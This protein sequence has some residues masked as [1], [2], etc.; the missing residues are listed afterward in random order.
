MQSFL[1]LSALICSVDSGVSLSDA[2]ADGGCKQTPLSAGSIAP[3]SGVLYNLQLEAAIL[4]TINNIDARHDLEMAQKEED[5]QL[6]FDL[7]LNLLQDELIQSKL[8]TQQQTKFAEEL[9]AEREKPFFLQPMFW[10]GVGA[11]AAVVI[12]VFIFG[13]VSGV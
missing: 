8:L 2:C 12:S 3:Y 4:T 7:Q 10:T 9:L 11:G 6:K 1:I 5:L 13:F